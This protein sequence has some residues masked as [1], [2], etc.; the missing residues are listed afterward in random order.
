M[1]LKEIFYV[2]GVDFEE[3]PNLLDIFD[4]LLQEYGGKAL[5]TQ[6]NGS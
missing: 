6:R 3:E 5:K 2:F 1:V 4:S